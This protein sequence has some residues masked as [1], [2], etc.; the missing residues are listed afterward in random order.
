MPTGPKHIHSY[1]LRHADETEEH[2]E[3]DCR[4]TIGEFSPPV[5]EEL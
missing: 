5:D 3:E 4:C 2:M 1:D